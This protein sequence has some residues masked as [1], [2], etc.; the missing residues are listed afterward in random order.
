MKNKI[1]KYINT[2]VDSSTLVV[3]RVLFGL[4]MMFSLIRFWAKGWIES[5]Y[6]SPI[7]H[8]KYYGFTCVQ[9]LGE[10]TYL[11]FF[12]CFLSALFITLG[13][14]Y[15]LSI[16]LFFLSF[17]YIQLIDK[18]TYLNH[19]YFISIVSFFLIFLPANCRFSLDSVKKE[20]SYT[21]IPKWN[22]DLIKILI[23][24]VYFYAGIA[25]INCDWLFRAMPLSLWLPQKYDLLYIGTI[26]S[27]EW[28]AFVMSW[29][30]MIFD[31]LIGIFL[32][33]KVYKNYAYGLVLIFHTLTVILFPKIGMFPFI[34]MSLTIIFLDKN[35]HKRFII[36]FNSFFSFKSNKET[37]AIKKG[38]KYIMSLLACVLIIHILF[39]L[40]HFLYDSK[41]LWSEEGYRF[42]WRVMLVQKSGH[43]IFTVTDKKSKKR[44][45]VDNTLFLTS[46]QESKMSFQPDMI[47]EYA[48]FLGD[49]YKNTGF[50]EPKVTAESFVSL[51]GRLSRR[52][53]KK[54][55]DL[56]MFKENLKGY[57]FITTF[58]DEIKNL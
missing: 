13:Y 20:I 35:I 37:K 21:N 29:C 26:L 11:L 44:I 47:L 8:F 5:I 31:V 4:Q 14:K 2:N 56:L 49:Y 38:N 39:P 36:K 50:I 55:I 25:K 32:F 45:V 46:F 33:S 3:F 17:T 57:N 16:T 18:T 51:N 19:Y 22:I 53:I 9:S 52:F 27:K 30:G 1:N 28:I 48:H 10:Y 40:R 41:L 24:T 12:I 6:I 15:K 54:N 43:T 42:S 34:M 23:V 58:K 7:F